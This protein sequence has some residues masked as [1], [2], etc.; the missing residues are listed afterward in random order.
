MT[1]QPR[2]RKDAAANRAR[3][4]AS[5]RRLFAQNGATV[6]FDAVARDAGVGNATIYRHFATARDLLEAIYEVRLDETEA[7]IG[8]LAVEAEAWERFAG[9]LRWLARDPDVVLIEVLHDPDVLGPAL[10]RRARAQWAWVWGTVK[11]AVSGGTMRDVSREDLQAIFFA[12]TEV[13]SNSH[14]TAE[15]SH[16]FVEIVLDGLRQD[17][18]STIPSRER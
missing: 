16:R 15:E 9:L 18:S 6:P 17:P 1:T 12:V 7:F 10:G 2:L 4:V 11:Q 8:T 13:A 5:A 14:I 3:I